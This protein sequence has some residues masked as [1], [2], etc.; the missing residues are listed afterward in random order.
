[1][2]NRGVYHYSHSDMSSLLLA[3]SLVQSTHDVEIEQLASGH[4]VSSLHALF[5]QLLDLNLME[6]L[7]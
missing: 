2:P 4:P 7:G 6:N 1:M 3:S 5:W